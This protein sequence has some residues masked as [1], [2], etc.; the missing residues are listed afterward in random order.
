[1]S[2]HLHKPDQG[3]A[4]QKGGIFTETAATEVVAG[5]GCDREPSVRPEDARVTEGSDMVVRGPEKTC[6]A[7]V[8]GHVVR[9]NDIT[10]HSS[11]ISLVTDIFTVLFTKN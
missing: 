10:R 8:K 4:G 3:S 6:S 2:V 5:T 1:M 11:T 7:N 9:F